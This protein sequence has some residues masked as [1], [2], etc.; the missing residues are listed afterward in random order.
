MKKKILRILSLGLSAVISAV[1]FCGCEGLTSQKTQSPSGIDKLYTAQCEITVEGED[2]EEILTYGG[3]LT[4][5]G[6]GMWELDL[7]KPDTVNGL[8][9]KLGENGITASLG[10]L[11][12]NLETDK[13]PSRAAFL[14]VFSALDN[15]AANINS[16]EFSENETNLCYRGTCGGEKYTLLCDKTNNLPCGLT[17]GKITVILVNF[18][19]TG[20]PESSTETTAEGSTAPEI[21]EETTVTVT[22]AETETV[23]VTLETTVSVTETEPLTIPSVTFTSAEETEENSDT[24]TSND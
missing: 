4:R 10:D 16:L 15:A 18:T 19:V 6:G 1:L 3:N 23:S 9:I 11:S 2:D 20:M 24:E 14:N 21:T 17:F 22:E 8:K 13:I 7:N 5:F 12:L